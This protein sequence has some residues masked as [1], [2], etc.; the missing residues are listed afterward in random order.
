MKVYLHLLIEGWSEVRYSGEQ[1]VL[2]PER[3]GFALRM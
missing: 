3:E 2:V 1:V